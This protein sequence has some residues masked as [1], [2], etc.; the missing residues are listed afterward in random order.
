VSPRFHAGHEHGKHMNEFATHEQ[1]S[2]AAA[3][4][5]YPA[6]GMNFFARS[7]VGIMGSNHTQGM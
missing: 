6:L 4:N 3:R 1:L 2:A 5:R 7:N